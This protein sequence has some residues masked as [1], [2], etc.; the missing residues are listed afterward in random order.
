MN[1]LSRI[2]YNLLL[3]LL[4]CSFVACDGPD[5][6]EIDFTEDAPT[7]PPRSTTTP[8]IIDEDSLTINEAELQELLT[9]APTAMA[10]ITQAVEFLR[11]FTSPIS[12]EEVRRRRPANVTLGPPTTE[13]EIG[14]LPENQVAL[15]LSGALTGY[16]YF[17]GSLDNIGKLATIELFSSNRQYQD[18]QNKRR[19]Q[20]LVKLL[21]KP[22][23]LSKIAEDDHGN[24]LYVI[25]WQLSGNLLRYQDEEQIGPSLTLDLLDA[26]K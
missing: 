13:I 17:Q 6:T 10:E 25:D 22:R 12:L 11:P 24:P 4:V 20:S 21:G 8:S 18:G 15:A 14:A 19:I 7:A 1:P 9:P 16:C 5:D 26:D 3:L 2:T 23:N